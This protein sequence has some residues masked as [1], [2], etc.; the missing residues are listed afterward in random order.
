MVWAVNPTNDTLAHLVSYLG[1]MA[2]ITLGRFEIGCRVR[3]HEP[4][5]KCTATAE[6]RRGMLMIAKEAISNIIEHAEATAVEIDIG[7]RDGRLRMAIQDDGRGL[8]N[9]RGLPAATTGRPHGPGGNG[10]GNMQSRAADLGGSCRIEPVLP[11]AAHG[12]R[13]IVEVPLESEVHA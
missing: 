3:T 6:M 7:V 13:V 12:T 11:P 10:L 9:G 8:D 4:L 2:S 5:P 1:Q